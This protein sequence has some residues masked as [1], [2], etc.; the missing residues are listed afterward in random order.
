M[1][2]VARIPGGG[3]AHSGGGAQSDPVVHAAVAVVATAVGPTV[4]Y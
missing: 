2:V 4:A 3:G 1:A